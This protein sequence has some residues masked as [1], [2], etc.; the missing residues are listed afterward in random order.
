MT[1]PIIVPP[2]VGDTIRGALAERDR[3]QGI[4]GMTRQAALVAHE[5]A[6]VQVTTR[7]VV[8]TVARWHQANP[9]ATQPDGRSTLLAG[10]WGGRAGRDWALA[11]A[12]TAA[13]SSE[14][15]SPVAAGVA[16]VAADTGRVLLLQRALSDDDPNGGKWELPGGK[17]DDGEGVYEAAQREFCE[18]A[19][20]PVP[21]K[22]AGGWTSPDGVYQGF[23]HVV[24]A[25]A[26]V[27]LNVDHED[28]HVS[29][30]DDPDGDAIEVVAW[31]SIDDADGNPVLRPEMQASTPW[32]DL[33][34][35]A[36]AR[37]PQ[38]AAI[39][40]PLPILEREHPSKAKLR[41]VSKRLAKVDD[42]LRKRLQAGAEVAMADGLRR[43]G[44]KVTQRAAKRSKAV[45]A[46]V[47]ACDG[48]YPDG[49]LAAAGITEQEALAHAFDA[50]AERADG[51]IAQAHERKARILATELGVD[52]TRLERTRQR[53]A[54]ARAVAVSVL[55]GGLA[56]L[57][58]DRLTRGHP[59]DPE[60]DGEVPVSP[61]V[62]GGLIGEAIAAADDRPVT[63][64]PA[65]GEAVVDK[66]APGATVE[67]ISDQGITLGIITDG[68]A[69][70]ER[71]VWRWNDSESPFAP[72]LDLD[73]T[74]ATADTIGDVWAK[75]PDVFP[76]NTPYW[77]PGDHHGC[78]CSWDSTF[79][80]T[81]EPEAVAAAAG[82]DET[83]HPR[84][85]KGKR[86]GGRFARKT[87]IASLHERA[88]QFWQEA[89]DPNGEDAV[90]V[91]PAAEA[92][93]Y[94]D[95][96]DMITEMAPELADTTGVQFTRHALNEALEYADAGMA[97]DLIIAQGEDVGVAG[98]LFLTW[99]DA[100]DEISDA[101]EGA[102]NSSP[103]AF[104][105]FVGSVGTVSGTGSAL[106]RE[107][108][109]AAAA[110]GVPLVGQP[111]ADALP[112][113]KSVG[114]VDDPTGE[115]LA[116]MGWTAEQTKEAAGG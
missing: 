17:L 115:G 67:V 63:G 50:F 107:A 5:L 46:S 98:A 79:E 27:V 22:L 110:K 37:Q 54:R 19:R 56:R 73:G 29:N 111:V 88:K 84:T 43:A 6:A 72:H 106:V 102:A 53:W 57:A 23:V 18:E 99:R 95:E 20:I 69:V 105:D 59:H 91:V 45:Q 44:V 24:P 96:L 15:A 11:M 16:V 82:F 66:W 40:D 3:R 62:P 78:N 76:Y 94:L 116:V 89:G 49:V 10:V 81:G 38:T 70:V 77:F 32:N 109:K 86:E 26:D 87:G 58:I 52:A 92:Q 83:R 108:A 41:R 30:P 12:R 104:V 68:R 14:P 1:D 4:P 55:A 36:R 80:A 42:D 34:D 71:I 7:D 51:W 93:R 97:A 2:I 65:S 75:S 74:E 39:A 33:R 100:G 64:D 61:L 48:V 101:T 60:P 112:F 31:W 13:A 35:V 25:E 8:R 9:D 85:P 113:W 28:R 103:L 21:G 90:A 114:W 47:A